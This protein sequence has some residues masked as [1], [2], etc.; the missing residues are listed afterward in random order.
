MTKQKKAIRLYEVSLF[1]D[2]LSKSIILMHRP[3]VRTP[4]C[5]TTCQDILHSTYLLTQELKQVTC[6]YSEA[7]AEALPQSLLI[8]RYYQQVLHPFLVSWHGIFFRNVA[9]QD[10]IMDADPRK[11]VGFRYRVN[12]EQE[13][14]KLQSVT[15]DLLVNLDPDYVVDAVCERGKTL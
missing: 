13:F 4:W 5:T 9:V 11:R 14:W 1:I 15:V 12:F 6:Y 2:R 8:L 7:D 10:N 3:F